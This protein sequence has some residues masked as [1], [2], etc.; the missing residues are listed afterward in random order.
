MNGI[1]AVMDLDARRKADR[2]IA[3]DRRAARR[4]YV[5]H[6]EEAAKEDLAYRKTKAIKLVEYRAAGEPAGVAQ[7]R[8]E[9]DAAGY[10]FKRDI[11][12]SLAKASLLKIDETEREATSVRDIHATSQKIDGLSA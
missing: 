10:R 8:A 3:E 5:R 9:A 1:P 11:A 2:S 7:I 4:D 6:S 12:E